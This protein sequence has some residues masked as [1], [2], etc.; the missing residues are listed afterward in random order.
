MPAY[1]DDE[2]P[3]LDARDLTQVTG[4]TGDATSSMM[5]PMMLMMRSRAQAPAPPPPAPA[6]K[7]KIMVDGVEQQPTSAGNGTFTSEV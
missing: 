7:P 6:W 3:T 2:L 4:G 1:H 5:M